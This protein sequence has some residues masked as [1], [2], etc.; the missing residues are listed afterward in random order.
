MSDPDD[1]PTLSAAPAPPT[2][3]FADALPRRYRV[4]AQ[5][6]AG[7]MGRV[8]RVHD[9]TLGRDVAIKL[10]ETATLH[11]PGRTHQR[12]RFAR[13]A[14]AAARVQH[15]NIAMVHDVD[16]EAGWLVMELV[17]GE[18]LRT[19]M[20]RGPLPAELVV[21]IATQVL[22]A[23]AAAH[24]VGIIH[25]D[26][27]PSNI[28]LATDGN[29][30]LVDFGIARMLDAAATHTGELTGTPAYMAP[31]QARGGTTDERT[32][33]YALGATLYRLVTGEL[34]PSF[35]APRDGVLATLE[36]ACAGQPALAR[37]VVRCLEPAPEARFPSARAALAALASRRA[38]HRRWLL[39][40]VGVGAAISIGAGLGIYV[41]T[42]S[43]ARDHR[44]DT[45][46][47]L[48]QRGENHKALQILADYLAAHGDDPD[49]RTIALLATWWQGDPLDDVK[50]RAIDLPL[51][52]AQRAMIEGID[53]IAHRRDPEAIAFLGQAARET[54]NA[55]EI[56]YTLGEAQWH[57]QHLD[58]GAATLERAFATDP[59]WEMA[60]H[61]VVEYRLS[62]GEGARL[63]PIADKLRA[64]DPAAAA[65]LDCEIAI[66]DRAYARAVTGAQA[67]LARTDL[68]KIAELY[69]CLAHAQALTGDLDAGIANAKIAFDLWPLAI[70]DGGGFAQYAEFFLYRNQLDAYLD[71]MRGK[72][73]SQRALALLLSRP[74]EPVDEPQ[75][76]WPAKRMAPLGAATW[77]LQ[78]HLHGVDAA[79]VVASY[80]EPEVRAWGQALAAEARGDRTAAIALLRESLEVPQKGDIHMLVAHRLAKL[81]HDAGDAAG[82][83]AA[84]E[85]VIAPRFYVNYRAVLLP[86]CLAWTKP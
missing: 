75:P 5:I 60:L 59:R 74:T 17:E 58:D 18:S 49:A 32:D 27:K 69:I 22:D 1:Q 54:P 38:P 73:S 21:R 16:P 82:A 14:R 64:G 71:L 25:R 31:E 77:M 53:L 11:G 28:M 35:E 70:G 50:K 24:A 55:V 83:K 80:P 63:V 44:L 84:C 78:Q 72:S 9:S 19:T 2:A 51:R 66:S 65:A 57:G 34:L 56:L 79:K 6:G 8:Y 41:G 85:E 33:L 40:A 3:A 42:P 68:P 61:H 4:I 29:V 26:I 81:L 39:Y 46:F 12:E 67:A 45:A 62:R 7:G 20:E 43:H 30:K 23:L 10:I 48:A 86:D 13:E 47:A 52:P 37:V 36:A 15:P 76:A